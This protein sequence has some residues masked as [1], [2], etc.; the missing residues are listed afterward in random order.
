MHIT[1]E[2][3]II[4]FHAFTTVKKP[5]KMVVIKCIGH[6]MSL[7]NINNTVNEHCNGLISDVHWTDTSYQF[8]QRNVPLA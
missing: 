6:T 2:N 5:G 1:R 4:V 7:Y 8:L 3:V